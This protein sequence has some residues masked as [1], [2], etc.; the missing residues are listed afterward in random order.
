M[1]DDPFVRHLDDQR[2][3]VSIVDAETGVSRVVLDTDDLLLEAPNWTLDG[4]ALVLNGDGRLWRLDLESRELT[5]IT[6]PGVPSLNNDHVL[7]PDGVHIFVSA[8]DGHIYR[9]ALDGSSGSSG[10][11]D[12]NGVERVSR[13]DDLLHFL[14]GVSPDGVEL[15]FIGIERPV[16]DSWG[17]GAVYVLRPDGERPRRLTEGDAPEDGSEYSPDGEWIYFNTEVFDGHAQ[18]ARMRTDGSGLEQLTDNERVNWFPHLAPHGSL[19][20][21]LAFPAGTVGHPADLWVDIM[22]VRD[23]NWRGAASIARVFGGQGTMNVNGW[24]PAGTE[25]AYVSYPRL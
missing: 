4:S 2:C 24:N 21:Y 16:D 11:D 13:D 14:H 15:A 7:D 18:I 25:F 10:S 5:D 12:G 3:V 19:A 6:P 22:L 17:T 8:N 9:A 1:S 20:A 23:G